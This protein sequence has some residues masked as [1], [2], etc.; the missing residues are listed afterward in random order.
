MVLSGSW[1][2]TMAANISTQPNSSRADIAWPRMIHPA[3][4]E[5]TDSMLIMSDATVGFMPFWPM[6]CKV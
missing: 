3:M 4:T 1:A 2:S 6:I 5:I